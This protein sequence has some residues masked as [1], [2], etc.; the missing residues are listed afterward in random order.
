[1][2][3]DIKLIHAHDFVRAA[4]VGE[5]DFE[6]SKKALVEI[7]SAAAHLVDYEILLDTRKAL[8]QMSVTNLWHLAAELRNLRNAFSRK[9]AVLCPVERF[10]DAAF[11]AHCCEN[12]GFRVRAFTS[13]EDA[14]NWLIGM[15]PDT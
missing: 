13:F 15:E 6:T 1:M 8:V 11:F 5:L 2:A 3:I 7:A 9:T 10:R 12:R 4:S 14:I